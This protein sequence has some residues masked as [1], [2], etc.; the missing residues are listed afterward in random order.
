MTR[1]DMTAPD[2]AIASA[3][4]ATNRRRPYDD[5]PHVVFYELTR[6]CDLVC[7][8]CRACAQSRADPQELGTD[9]SRKLLAQLTEFSR[10][11]LV[12]LTGGDPLKRADLFALIEY[13]VSLGLEISLTPSA[14]PLVTRKV[15]VQLQSCG[16]SRLA[17][18]L[19]GNDAASHDAVRGVSGSFHRTLE[20]LADARSCGLPTQVNTTLTPDNFE[21][22]ERFAAIL[23]GLDIV[24]WSVFFLVPMGRAAG[25]RCLNAAQCEIAFEKLWRQSQLQSF[26]IKTTEAPHYRRFI[27]QRQRM[28]TPKRSGSAPT[29]LKQR[30]SHSSRA[31][32][33]NDGKGI[34]F[35]SHT[36]EIQP[37]G[38]LPL[39][40][41]QFPD[42]N[43]VTVYRNSPIFR[44]LRDP[45]RLQGKCG[46]CE[47]RELCGG[48]RA[49]AFAIAGS[50]HA[51]EPDCA[52][53]PG[54]WS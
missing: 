16:V 22:I 51:E 44:G 42:D 8:H 41:G 24:M 4:R 19:D 10:P 43:L 53:L 40:C 1:F 15:V 49:R 7:L 26:R 29:D 12:V 11:P 52:Y 9:L 2:T 28:L 30:L 47:Y 48:S 39:H 23:A 50:A 17:V 31:L 37:S 45:D 36:G 13:G 33:T 5:S 18:S 25:A 20:I 6:A 14:T 54:H 21:H 38:F 3:R 35:V 32:A 46:V 27:A 34:L